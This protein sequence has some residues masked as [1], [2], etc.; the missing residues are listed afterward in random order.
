MTATPASLLK[1]AQDQCD[2]TP[3]NP[4]DP[5]RPRGLCCEGVE[6]APLWEQAEIND[7]MASAIFSEIRETLKAIGC[8]HDESTH[9]QTPP[10]MY[11]QWIACAAQSL[12]S[13]AR[14]WREHVER[15]AAIC[16]EDVGCIEFSKALQAACRKLE[17]QRDR[18]REALEKYGEHDRP[19]VLS[20]FEVFDPK[21]GH[22]YKSIWYET[23]PPCECGLDK[24]L[25]SEKP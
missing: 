20:F 13:D 6:G 12:L 7:G 8:R 17:T 3:V 1:A 21:I 19:C 5:P 22:K 11:A 23:P 9:A 16:P 18:Y 24:A 10:M 25:A 4:G 14:K 2:H 15:E